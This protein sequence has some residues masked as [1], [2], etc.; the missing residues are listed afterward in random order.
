MNSPDAI[1]KRYIDLLT[2]MPRILTTE[3]YVFVHAGLDFRKDDP[4]TESTP[5]DL[6]WSR[7]YQVDPAKIGGRILITGH[8]VTPLFEIKASLGSHRIR[9][10]NGCYDKCEICC[11]S[12]VALNLDT[13]VLLVQENIE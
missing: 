4:I 10:D 7:D 11:G 5:H 3:D 2:Q 1:P 13:R 8:C 6:L 12:L 9:L